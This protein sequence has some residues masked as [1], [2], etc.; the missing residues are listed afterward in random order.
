MAWTAR[1]SVGLSDDGGHEA[2]SRTRQSP[3]ATH[4]SDYVVV[5]TFRCRRHQ[6]PASSGEQTFSW[7]QLFWTLASVSATCVSCL[8]LFSFYMRIN[9]LIGWLII[10]QSE[11]R[12]NLFSC[13]ALLFQ[14]FHWIRRNKKTWPAFVY[15]IRFNTYWAE[16]WWKLR[17]GNIEWSA[18]TF[19]PVIHSSD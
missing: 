3:W 9:W 2:P 14:S 4:D 19:D 13:T 11:K 18:A 5:T 1:S 15:N 6:P 12:S 10:R 16:C 17:D 8:F 7:S